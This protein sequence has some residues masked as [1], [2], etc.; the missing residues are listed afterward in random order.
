MQTRS[1]YSFGPYQLHEGGR[2]LA[3]QTEPVGLSD[4]Q[5]NI[6]LL[7]VSRSPRVVAKDALIDAAWKAVEVGDN[8]LE[9]AISSLRRVLDAGPEGSPYIETLTRRGYRFRVPV[10]APVHPPPQCRDRRSW[11]VARA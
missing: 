9:Q 11:D 5:L 8:A 6:L 1:P 10:S 2:W 7:L 4:R 3:R